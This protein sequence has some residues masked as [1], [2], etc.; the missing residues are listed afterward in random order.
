VEERRP[1][2]KP[3]R[4][5]VRIARVS[6]GDAADTPPR[7]AVNAFAANLARVGRLIARGALTEP[8][9]DLLLFRASDLAEA[10]RILRTD[11]WRTV[12][13]VG[14][15]LLAWDPGTA[16]SGVNLEPAPAR[17]SGRLTALQRVAV[18]V[19]DRDRAVAWYRDVLGLRVREEDPE[20]GFVELALG[21]GTAGLSLVAP[22]PEWGEPFFSETEV[23][24]GRPTGIVFETDSTAALE[25]RLRHVGA[26]VT[27]G[28]RPQPWG[29]TTIRFCDPDGNEFLAFDGGPPP[30]TAAAPGTPV[31]E[32]RGGSKRSTAT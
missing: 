24:I 18:V 14:Y 27:D 28:P 4:V 23:R 17:G 10:R 21:R 32:G 16:A 5:Y 3:R 26:R 30:A 20:S 19:R 15:E 6:P 13:E 9:G 2:P 22:R 8:V 25:L 1:G 31:P 7:R 29:G 12:P 11:P